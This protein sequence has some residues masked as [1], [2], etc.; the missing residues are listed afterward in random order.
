MKKILVFCCSLALTSTVFADSLFSDKEVNVDLG[1]VYTVL[2]PAGFAHTFN[3]PLKGGNFGLA[4]SSIVWNGNYGAGLSM[5]V[6][7][8]TVP[9]DG[10]LDWSSA[11]IGLRLLDF[12]FPTFSPQFK[13]GV[14]KSFTTGVPFTSA[15]LLLEKRWSKHFGTVV[16]GTYDF[17]FDGHDSLMGVLAARW[18]F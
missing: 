13:L 18:A 4:L 6:K 3:T 2:E 10:I 17:S 5:G 16:G 12:P 8:L 11:D 14:G 9:H 7:D 15:S 1:T